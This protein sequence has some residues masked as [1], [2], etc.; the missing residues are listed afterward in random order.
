[1]LSI[2]TF[3]REFIRKHRR[4]PKVRIADPTKSKDLQILLRTKPLGFSEYDLNI[5]IQDW[6]ILIFD[7]EFQFDDFEDFTVLLSDTAISPYL[8]HW[9]SIYSRDLTKYAAASDMDECRRVLIEILK[10]PEI[11]CRKI[12]ETVH[13]QNIPEEW[14][15]IGLHSKER[16]LKIKARLLAM[17]VFEIRLYFGMTEKNIAEKI[18]PYIP[19]QTMT[20][21]DSDLLKV[22]LDLSE[23]HTKNN[24][25][26]KNFLSI[27]I[28]LDFNKFNQRWRYESTSLIFKAMDDLLGTPVLIEWSHRFF[29]RS[30]F[31]LSSKLCPPEHLKAS[32]QKESRLKEILEEILFSS[33]VSFPGSGKV[34][35]VKGCDRKGGQL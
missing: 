4:W 22:L 32:S 26:T 21:T 29:E 15:V 17:M 3:I 5:S 24:L 18:F 6:A 12:R 7:Q 28:S 1:M 33:E 13:S 25:K 11:S 23:M 35:D 31:Y 8:S 19:F 2:G 10:R 14:L 27:V 9:Y 30:F 34:E 16:E 20:W